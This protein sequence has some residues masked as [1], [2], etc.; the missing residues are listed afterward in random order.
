MD[1][2]GSVSPK[3]AASARRVIK[4]S[5]DMDTQTDTPVMSEIIT[6]IYDLNQNTSLKSSDYLN[7]VKSVQD[8]VLQKQEAGL[9]SGGDA[10]K[11]THQIQT[12]TQKRV[13]DATKSVGYKFG[14]AN[15][16]FEVLPPEYRGA[17]T[18]ELFYASFGQDL[19]KQQLDGHATQIIDQINKKRR[20]DALSIISK[21]TNDDV[22]LSA[23]GYSRQDVAYTAKARG[24][25][26]EQ[27]IE[28]MRSKFKTRPARKRVVTGTAPDITE[29]LDGTEE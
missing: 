9:L 3:A 27:V 20:N 7:G 13:S 4:S 2:E 19:S 29:T 25:T 1:M 5:D 15:K 16:K 10:T 14:S 6:Q 26:Q 28:A 12:L 23:A 8:L 18:R 11:L 24:L 22:F 21:T 17:A